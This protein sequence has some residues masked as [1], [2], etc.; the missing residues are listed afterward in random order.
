MTYRLTDR[1]ELLTPS[2]ERLEFIAGVTAPSGAWKAGVEHGLQD[3]YSESDEHG[4]VTQ[5]SYLQVFK[6]PKSQ[7]KGHHQPRVDQKVGGRFHCFCGPLAA[8]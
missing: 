3:D 4:R 8:P 5:I 6:P 1:Q 7:S 2:I